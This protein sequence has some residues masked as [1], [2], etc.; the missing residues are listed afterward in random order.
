MAEINAAQ[1]GTSPRFEQE[2]LV[3]FY[4]YQVDIAV[5]D[6]IRQNLNDPTISNLNEEIIKWLEFANNHSNDPILFQAYV[7]RG[8]YGNA[9]SI[10]NSLSTNHETDEMAAFFQTYL[11]LVQ[12][13]KSWTVLQNNPGMKET[14]TKLALQI[15]KPGSAYAQGALALAFGSEAYDLVEGE[16]LTGARFSEPSKKNNE[17]SLGNGTIK[18]AAFPNPFKNELNVSYEFTEPSSNNSISL[19]EVGTGRILQQ[20]NNVEMKGIILFDT[21]NISSGLYMIS[22]K[23]NNK[24]ASFIKVVNIR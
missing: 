18:V 12:N 14:V 11:G 10:I 21:E 16:S 15:D 24:P 4:N 3:R 2:E 22:I 13:G 20:R 6:I 17:I 7:N 23:Q 8:D 9:Q 5:N 19:I 1:V